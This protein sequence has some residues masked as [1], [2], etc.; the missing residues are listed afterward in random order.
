[1]P[2]QAQLHWGSGQP[3]RPP[4]P[5]PV[6][7][8]LALRRLLARTMSVR[9]PCWGDVEEA[10]RATGVALGCT[11]RAT[12]TVLAARRRMWLQVAW[13]VP[14]VRG[15]DRSRTQ[16]WLYPM[17]GRPD[18]HRRPPRLLLGVAVNITPPSRRREEVSSLILP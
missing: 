14:A 12:G 18:M 16:Q 4:T 6:L 17:R 7:F 10:R 9:F 3:T 11:T 13:A 2:T 15:S 8:F 1:M 5:R